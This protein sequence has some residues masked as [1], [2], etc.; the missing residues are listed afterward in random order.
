MNPSQ[1]HAE[2]VSEIEKHNRAYYIDNASVISDYEYDMLYK[3]LVDLEKKHPELIASYSPTQRV[4]AAPLGEFKTYRHHPP[5]QSLDNVYSEEELMDFFKRLQKLLPGEKI[6]YVVEPKIDGVAVSLRY[7]NGI[8]V[9]GGTRGDGAEGDDITLNLKTLKQLPLRLAHGPQFLEARGEVFLSFSGF[10][11]MNLQR[12]ETGEP[13]FANP[14]NAA[15]GTLK[16][17]DSREVAKRPLWIILYAVGD[18]V[19]DTFFTQME[20]LQKLHELGLPTS[21]WSKLCRT[22]KDVLAALQD[23][24]QER[25]SFEYPTD[26]AVIKVNDFTQQE[27]LKSTAKAPRWAIAYKFAPEQAE[28]RLLA[29]TLQVGR[30][31]VVTP[32]AELEPTLLSGT[33]VSRATLHNFAEIARKDIH[34]NDVVILQKAGEIIPEVVK[35]NLAKRSHDAKKIQRPTHCPSCGSFLNQEEVFLRCGNEVCSEKNKRRLQHFAQRGAMDIE[36]LGESLVEQLVN[37]KLVKTID[38]IYDLEAK[39][40]IFLERMG[41]KSAENLINAIQTSKKRPLW[42]L[43]FGLG[44]LHVGAGI[45]QRLEKVFV[46]LDKLVDASFEDLCKVDDVGEIVAQSIYKFFREPETKRLMEALRKHGLNF[47]TQTIETQ[48]SL[49][50]GKKFVITGTLSKPREAFEEK[51]RREGGEV[52]NTISSKTD[53]LLVGESPGSKLD[54]AR[55]LGVKILD[56]DAFEKLAAGE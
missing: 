12:E 30:T 40:I 23:L 33:T 39:Q 46:S 15:A 53:Y 18:V 10:R 48:T 37:R 11:H 52:M 19:G 8:F 49:L 7:E 45:A 32:V 5:M 54:K 2:L 50:T 6:E 16:L 14:R 22:E 4:G 35:V 34:I 17:L 20:T 47:K 1:R 27:I 28:A 56:E 36:G 42:R 44:I 9:A 25:H 38:Q 51:I 43:I 41:T 26:G 3:E 24:D 31:G 55:R 29:I 13:L 21:G